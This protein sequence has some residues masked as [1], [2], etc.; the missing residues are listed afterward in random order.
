[1]IA[2]LE[3]NK[4]GFRGPV[5]LIGM[6][7]SGTKLLRGLLN[8]HPLIGICSV[9]T[10]FI[11]Y[12]AKHWHAFGDLSEATIFQDFYKT[13]TRFPYFIYMREMGKLIESDVWFNLCN[14]FTLSG[15][16]EALIR[17]D[18]NVSC[19]SKKIWGDKSPSYINN[20]FLLKELF[21]Q[22]KFIHIIRDVRDYCLSINNAWGKNMI[23][24]AQRWVDC[25]VKAKRDA[26]HFPESYLEVRYEDLLKEPEI[27]LHRLTNFMGIEFDIKLLN[28]SSPS[29]NLGATKGK[30]KIIKE[31]KNK[32]LRLMAPQTRRKIESISLEVLQSCGYNSDYS[33]KSQRVS[34]I[35]MSIF[36]GLDAL[37]LIKFE[38]K[39]R[40]IWKALKFQYRYFNVSGNRRAF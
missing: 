3:R 26:A 28:L 14:N 16:F 20:L 39:K 34:S 19:H 17:H 7:R 29:E 25:I 1:M 12:W 10:E 18:A 15:V 2:K 22:A 5:F 13:S 23:R 36:Q 9:E 40:G 35:Q 33:G 27:A 21:P 37:N 30:K 4:E 24:A 8:E 32:Y 38:S 11:P 6:P 31:N